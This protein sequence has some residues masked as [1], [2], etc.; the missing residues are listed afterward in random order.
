MSAVLKLTSGSLRVAH[1]QLATTKRLICKNYWATGWFNNFRPATK[2][3]VALFNCALCIL[4]LTLSPHSFTPS[5]VCCCLADP[6]TA[7]HTY[8]QLKSKEFTG[9]NQYR[10]YSSGGQDS[11]SSSSSSSNGKWFAL[12]LLLSG[13]GGAGIAYQNGLFDKSGH[14]KPV[15][16][17][18]AEKKTKSKSNFNQQFTHSNPF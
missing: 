6:V 14:S 18:I 13:A 5:S 3:L 2:N 1:R 7:S 9:T 17:T 4:R 10:Y 15:E 12:A 8:S 11:S 16:K